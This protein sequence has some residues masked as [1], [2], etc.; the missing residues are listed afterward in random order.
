MASKHGRGG[1][2]PFEPRIRRNS[3]TANHTNDI[4]HARHMAEN[5]VD[6]QNNLDN[7]LHEPARL[8]MAVRQGKP[9]MT[10]KWR[11]EGNQRNRNQRPPRERE[12][13][14]RSPLSRRIEGPPPGRDRFERDDFQ[15][16]PTRKRDHSSGPR[17]PPPRR[18]SLSPAESPRPQPGRRY[19][20]PESAYT[21]RES[22]PTR[23]PKRRRTRSPSRS[24]W[25]DRGFDDRRRFSRSRSRER[26][27]PRETRPGSRREFS[28]RRSSPPR[29]AGRPAPRH[30]PPE[31]DTYIPERRRP[32]SPPRRGPRRSSSPRQRSITPPFR[33]R[34]PS[35]PSRRYPSRP[36]SPSSY[37]DSPLPS[38]RGPP[39]KFTPEPQYRGKPVSRT[40]SPAG[41]FDRESMDGPF[42]VRGHYG[43]PNYVPRGRGQRLY[44]NNRGSY[45]ASSIA[46]SPN[47][48]HHG[49]PQ[50]NTSYRGGRGG[51]NGPQQPYNQ[52]HSNT[53]AHRQNN[54]SGAG[55]SQEEY[56]R[57][58]QPPPPNHPQNTQQNRPYRGGRGQQRGAHPAQHGQD[59]RFSGQD[60]PESNTSQRGRGGA[61]S[62][63]PWNQRG[64]G[65]ASTQA[66]PGSNS[67]RRSPAPPHQGPR[68]TTSTTRELTAAQTVRDTRIDDD[69]HRE[70]ENNGLP[71][72]TPSG[73]KD[74][75]KISF[76][77]KQK[78]PP[79]SPVRP[80][81]ADLSETVKAPPTKPALDRPPPTQPR[82]NKFQDHRPYNQTQ[83]FNQNN[84]RTHL[85]RRKDDQEPAF[86]PPKG[87][88]AQ[89]QY[90]A[91][92]TKP[93][94][95]QPPSRPRSRSPPTQPAKKLKS[96][97][98]AKPTLTPAMAASE[99]VYYRKP[100]NESVVGA[101]TYGKV[102]KAIHIFTK[103]LVALKKIRMEGE[104]DGFP[105]TAVRE[106]KLLQ[107]LRHNHVVELMEVMVEKNE[108]F[109]VFEYMSHD[110]TGLINHPTFKL[111]DAHKKDLGRQM[112]EGL[113]F[114]HRRCVMHRDIKAANL[115]ISNRGQLK[116]A[117]FGLARFYTKSRKLDYTNRVIT[118]WYRPPELLLGE[119]QYGPAVD[120]WSAACVFM[121]MF[122]RKAIFPGEGGELSQLDK[123]YNML[124]TPSKT[125]WPG[126]AEMP[127]YE[128]MHPATATTSSGEKRKRLFEQ[129]Y[130]DVLSPAAMDLV[131]QIFQYDPAQR[132]DAA[133]ILE[134]DYFCVE[135][136]EARQA[137]ELADV[138]G[139]WHEYESKAHRKENERREKEKRKEEHAKEREKRKVKD[140]G[141]DSSTAEHGGKKHKSDRDRDRDSQG[142]RVDEAPAAPMPVG[143]EDDMSDGEGSARMSMS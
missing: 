72:D 2:A 84:H 99:S 100:G 117:D 33:R 111:S 114:L 50:S 106:I 6:H 11:T 8:S 17:R 79:Q 48:S 131:S 51:W 81:P 125:E 28:P 56:F 26:F 126:I 30:A 22:S 49:S 35:P 132:P 137:V 139:D 40:P 24:D 123:I 52:Q 96:E 45:R 31:V 128:L 34:S 23:F 38:R 80:P 41:E 119:T 16:R 110:M 9:P 83:N 37:H 69:E 21:S 113:E 86:R 122:T 91:E 97:T 93:P 135:A 105:I 10:N 112:F 109:M 57:S 101:G 89:P 76:A 136:P 92:R 3:A 64:R 61:F 12:G 25:S 74:T 5:E 129:Q 95:A 143:E 127:W 102:F 1:F 94:N 120:I 71:L 55:Q 15:N 133:T 77:F 115:L 82:G 39:R 18:T 98:P 59:R 60:Y 66:G 103:D 32:V 107:N 46:V 141:L 19:H 20:P 118:I 44:H 13:R 43:N 63:A 14:S 140:A 142:A 108:C 104:R 121:E 27:D 85:D 70:P 65:G 29:P 67:L 47:S 130:S 42:A 78:P 4:D 116:Y 68:D 58:Q 53:Q 124:G 87:P 134:H 75:S 73:P 7:D 62:N 54:F 138:G 90:H 88:A 36:G